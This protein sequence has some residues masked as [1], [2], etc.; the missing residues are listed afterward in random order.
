MVRIRAFEARVVELV[1]ANE[2][3]GV[4]HEYV[5]EE[6]VAVG[7]CSALTLADGITSTHRGHGHLLAKGGTPDRML[8]ELMGRD[9]GY[10]R[11]DAYC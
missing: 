9:A 1:N 10:N 4:T 2:I 7:I 6:A 11:L 3:A 8:A 5:G